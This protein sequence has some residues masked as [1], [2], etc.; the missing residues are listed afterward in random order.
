VHLAAGEAVGKARVLRN[1]FGEVRLERL[2]AQREL[3]LE[4]V[5]VPARR[6][7]IG[8][9]H[10]RAQ[11]HAALGALAPDDRMIDAAVG[12]AHEVAARGAFAIERALDRH[13]GVDP[14]A[15]VKPLAAQ[16]GQQTGG[17]GDTGGV[18]LEVAPH[19]RALPEAVEVHDV[20]GDALGAQA[21]RLLQHRSFRERYEGRR[22]PQAERPLR[23]HRRPAG[24][25]RIRGQDLLRRPRDQVVVELLAVG[26]DVVGAIGGAAQ[27]HAHR[28]RH[29]DE[30]SVAPAAH[31]H[32]QIL[33]G[34]VGAR[35]VRVAVP[36]P[37]A[38]AHQ[39]QAGEALTAAIKVVF[40]V[41]EHRLDDA[42]DAP[43]RVVRQ[44]L[45]LQARAGAEPLPGEVDVVGHLVGEQQP[46]R[47]SERQSPRVEARLDGEV[48]GAQRDPVGGAVDR[49]PAGVGVADDVAEG[50][51]D[52]QRSRR[53][54]HADDARRDGAHRDP[55]RGQAL[56][57][58]RELQPRRRPLP[59]EGPN[60]PEIAR[61]HR[62][63]P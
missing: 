59:A 48:L 43:G 61:L 42:E 60:D 52:G 4:L 46:V 13:V 26:F 18:P 12:T 57:G 16:R 11:P 53:D 17:V 15:A 63:T 54:P 21:P 39:V 38:P 6:V 29:V 10:D 19:L 2:R 36:D 58:A 33:V 14:Q 55:G 45:D 49:P 44:R 50:F 41:Q 30:Q 7:G 62:S 51:D 25:P 20:A 22:G 34:E 9:V 28:G 35:A 40:G 37:E 24:Q 5:A 3:G 56:R 23:R 47:G 8:E 31:Q 27:V 1:L 32:R